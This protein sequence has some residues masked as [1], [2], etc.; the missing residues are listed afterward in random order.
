MVFSNIVNDTDD[1]T[2]GNTDEHGLFIK[3]FCVYPCLSVVK[4]NLC[5]YDVSFSDISIK[6]EL[7]KAGSSSQAD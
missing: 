6:K 2:T 5:L 1:E 7:G 3:F 4:N